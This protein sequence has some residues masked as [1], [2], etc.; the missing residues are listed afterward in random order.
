M[1]ELLGIGRMEILSFKGL[2]YRKRLKK[3]LD[4]LVIL[5]VVLIV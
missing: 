5:V 4:G 3:L 2:R 1:K